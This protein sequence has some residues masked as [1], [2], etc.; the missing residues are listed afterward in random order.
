MPLTLAQGASIPSVVF[1]V[2]SNAASWQLAN[3]KNVID[4]RIGVLPSEDKL[5]RVHPFVRDESLLT[6][7]EFVR[8]NV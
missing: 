8:I 5:P 6:V 1:D 7:S 3:G 2:Y 4:R